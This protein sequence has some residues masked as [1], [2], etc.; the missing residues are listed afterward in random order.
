MVCMVAAICLKGREWQSINVDSAVVFQGPEWAWTG[1]DWAA[2]GS[3]DVNP[4]L[5]ND[6]RRVLAPFLVPGLAAVR[7]RSTCV[8]S[9]NLYLSDLNWGLHLLKEREKKKEEKKNT[10]CQTIWYQNHT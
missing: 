2:T 4:Q 10:L 7:I 8:P 6:P 1:I 5:V 3:D 9:F